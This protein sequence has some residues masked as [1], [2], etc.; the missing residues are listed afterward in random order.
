[1]ADHRTW[2]PFAFGG[3]SGNQRNRRSPWECASSSTRRWKP[4][5]TGC[6]RV[7]PRCCT[8]NRRRRST[9]W[10]FVLAP[11]PRARRPVRTP[12]RAGRPHSLGHALWPAR[13][14]AVLPLTDAADAR[15]RGSCNC[16]VR[17]EGPRL[18]R[19]AAFVPAVQLGSG[20]GTNMRWCWRADA[21]PLGGPFL[22][23]SD[24]NGPIVGSG[25]QAGGRE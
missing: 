19:A 7:G 1:M 16:R 12:W 21:C 8:N 13:T 10:I 15:R 6:F 24:A 22:A 25:W 9:P 14:N 3:G 5:P 2:R 4:E 23:S 11:A 20:S 17:E 18:R